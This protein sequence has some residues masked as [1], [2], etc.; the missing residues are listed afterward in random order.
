MTKKLT[1]TAISLSAATALIIATFVWQGVPKSEGSGDDGEEV[2]L[3]AEA[4]QHNERYGDPAAPATLAGCQ[5]ALQHALTLFQAEAPA[6][7]T[8]G[9]VAQFDA[10]IDQC[11]A[12]GS[13]AEV[14]CI[15]E[16]E[17]LAEMDGCVFDTGEG[18]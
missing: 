8:L 13:E 18:L 4:Q 7:Q 2:E 3:T 12:D 17:T 11:V 16:A 10:M 14:N 15:L 9:A 5:D 1:L 6:D